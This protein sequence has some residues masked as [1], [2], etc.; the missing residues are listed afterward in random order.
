M[1]GQQ[2]K[3]NALLGNMTSYLLCLMQDEKLNHML[4]NTRLFLYAQI[5]TAIRWY[6]TVIKHC[7]HYF[8][9]NNLR[10]KWDESFPGNPLKKKKNFWKINRKFSISKIYIRPQFPMEWL[11]IERDHSVMEKLMWLVCCDKSMRRRS[12]D[13]CPHL[14]SYRFSNGSIPEQL[15]GTLIMNNC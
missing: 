14:D 13:A 3:G 2:K 1:L 12:R 4:S 8:C 10:R 11:H 9:M 15:Q 6:H 7:G 5:S